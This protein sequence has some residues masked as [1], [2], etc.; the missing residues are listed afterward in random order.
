MR[1]FLDLLPVMRNA[2]ERVS[3]VVD[4]DRHGG[5]EIRCPLQKS[6]I[7]GPYG[8]PHGE[9][10]HRGRRNTAAWVDL[11]S[12]AVAR[13]VVVRRARIVSEPVTDCIRYE[14][15][16]VPGELAQYLQTFER[17]RS[18]AVYGAEARALILKAIEALH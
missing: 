5:S 2:F 16:S 15:A 6:G 10:R 12:S 17:L 13:G 4:G 18:M 11:V 3:A 14:H 9:E 8:D 7:A 1:P